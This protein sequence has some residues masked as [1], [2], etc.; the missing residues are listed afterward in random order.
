[1]SEAD[2]QALGVPADLEARANYVRLDYAKSNYAP[3]RDAEW[4]QKVPYT[5]GNG[6]VVPA[7]VP[8]T[9][10]P[11]KVATLNDLAALAAAV[12]VGTHGGTPWS[13]RL[14]KEPR[15]ISR[16]LEQFG[17]HG[18]AE[19]DVMARLQSECSMETA[20]WRNTDRRH[21]VTGLRID[22]Q[23]TVQWEQA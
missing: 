9:P 12:Q 4:F 13:Q 19:K 8:W 1:M 16:L 21:W 22:G 10:P 6:E 7:A 5:L 2:A 15:S 14:S 3:L 17:F 18:D 20:K 11:P 23:P